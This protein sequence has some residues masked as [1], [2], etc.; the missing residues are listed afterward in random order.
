MEFEL[1]ISRPGEFMEIF[2]NVISH[3]KWKYTIRKKTLWPNIKCD[4]PG[5]I[6]M[7]TRRAR[8]MR[9]VEYLKGHGFFIFCH[10]KVM[11]LKKF[12]MSTNPGSVTFCLM[13]SHMMGC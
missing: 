12:R 13:T 1:L 7:H 5:N 9:K 6:L 10:G 4:I 3:G 2:R 8:C 11:E